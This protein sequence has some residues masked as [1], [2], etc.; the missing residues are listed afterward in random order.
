MNWL[1]L[2][3]T[4][5]YCKGMWLSH[6]EFAHILYNFFNLTRISL[7]FMTIRIS[8]INV[9]AIL[10]L[11]SNIINKPWML[12]N[13]PTATY[14]SINSIIEISF[15]SFLKNSFSYYTKGSADLTIRSDGCGCFCKQK[16]EP[17]TKLRS[18]FVCIQT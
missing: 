10:H 8:N 5:S 17:F 9:I 18:M 1:K 3:Y 15:N 7:I 13:W 2:I 12:W 6:N 14:S 11:Q 16:L 4:A